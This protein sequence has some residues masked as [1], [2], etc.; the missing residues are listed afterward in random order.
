MQKKLNQQLYFLILILFLQFILIQIAKN[1]NSFLQF[2]SSNI[3]PNYNQNLIDF[4]SRFNFPIG[5]I[6]YVFLGLILIFLIV[7]ALKHFIFNDKLGLK[8]ILISLLLIINLVYLLFN[9]SW[10]LNYAKKSFTSEFY[11]EKVE[12]KE[13]KVIAENELVLAKFYRKKV[14]E[15]INGV[16]E[17]QLTPN[18]LNKKIVIDQLSLYSLAFLNNQYFV[19]KV[20][21]KPSYFSEISNHLGILGYYNPFTAEAN[22]NARST[23]LNRPITIAHE[24]AHQI[25]YAPENEANFMAYVIAD[26]S[27]YEYLK[28]SA[29]YKT[30]MSVLRQLL[31]TE[32]EFVQTILD[33]F[34]DG[35]QRDRANE[36][37]HNQKYSGLANDVFSNLNDAYLKANQQEGITSYSKYVLFVAAYYRWKS[38][39]N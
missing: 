4:T 31:F 16:F 13:L 23:A 10:S 29:H 18:E 39:I 34:S 11:L 36:I 35:M 38:E 9:F 1:S 30:L 3:Y 33:N 15:D 6:F 12:T 24:V 26:L 17:L 2:Y 28:Y 14:K 19:E 27:D 7:L 37:A 5:E 8:K 22:Y 32:P 21:I 20:N 25:G